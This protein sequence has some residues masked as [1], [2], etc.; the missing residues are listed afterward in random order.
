MKKS[1]IIACDTFR[2]AAID[3]LH[4]F[5]KSSNCDFFSQK[6][7]N[8]G[9]VLYDALIFAK[10]NNHS[11]IIIDTA[12]RLENKEHLMSELEKLQRILY[13]NFK[14]EEINVEKILV[15]DSNTG[16]NALSQ[17]R[18]FHKAIKINGIV[19]SKFDSSSKAGI[20]LSLVHELNLPIYFIGNGEKVEDLSIFNSNY[21]IQEFLGVQNKTAYEG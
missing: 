3:Q 2:A 5:A 19:L 14:S 17:A 11:T 15:L 13:K 20:I 1:L 21:Y 9:A 4:Y 8:P 18:Q 10:K 12:G 7:K 6:K 16:K